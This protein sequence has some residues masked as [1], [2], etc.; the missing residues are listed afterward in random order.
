MCGITGYQGTFPDLRA[1]AA[2]G[3]ASNACRGSLDSLLGADALDYPAP[4]ACSGVIRPS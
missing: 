1:Q 2:E 4:G 3:V